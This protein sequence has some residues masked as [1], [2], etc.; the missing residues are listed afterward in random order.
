[1]ILK[2]TQ[3]ERDAIGR[4]PEYE[5]KGSHV[6]LLLADIET[7]E[8]RLTDTKNERD[9]FIGIARANCGHLFDEWL[10]MKQERDAAVRAV[11]QEGV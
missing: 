6:D 4:L 9:R 5:I 8:G 7:L 3:E 1:M 10:K 11:S 2:T